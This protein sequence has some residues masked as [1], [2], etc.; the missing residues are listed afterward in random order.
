[1]RGSRMVLCCL[2][3]AVVVGTLQYLLPSTLNASGASFL[4]HAYQ[5]IHNET[6]E[7][8]MIF[9]NSITQDWPWGL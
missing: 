8:F 6:L 4:H 9:M 1:M 3:L 7:C 5:N 2:A